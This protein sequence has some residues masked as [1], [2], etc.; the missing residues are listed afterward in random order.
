M[1]DRIPQAVLDQYRRRGWHITAAGLPDAGITTGPCG[2]C[3]QPTLLYG[4]NGRPL[5]PSCEGG[6]DA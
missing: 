5:C 4:P 3:R 2:R 6:T 1:P